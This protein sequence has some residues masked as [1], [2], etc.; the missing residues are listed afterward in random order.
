MRSIAL[1]AVMA[2]CQVTLAAGPAAGQQRRVVTRPPEELLAA[3]VR[4]SEVGRP[5]SEASLD[6]IAVL[7]GLADYRQPMGTVLDGLEGLALNG[8]TPT[9]RA[10]AA[11][12]LSKAGSRQARQPRVGN[13]AQLE[14]LYGRTS[15]PGV[16]AAVIAGLSKAVE[17]PNALAFLEGV[18]TR[19][20]KDYPGSAI[21]AM[22]SIAAHEEQ[23]RAVLK[24]L[25]D[26]DAVHEPD[27]VQW[28]NHVAERGYRIR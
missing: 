25:R 19:D 15:D 9:V 6:L 3:L 12:S 23:G 18:A 10:R 22:A 20:G 7:V 13:V 26:T 28:L 16:R 21:D 1:W 4:D 8:A 11:L 2:A 5:L 14:R 24:R 27:A 17:R